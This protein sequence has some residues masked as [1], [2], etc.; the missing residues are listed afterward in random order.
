MGTI[1]R[2]HPWCVHL[3]TG[4][5]MLM[6]KQNSRTTLWN[7]EISI[8]VSCSILQKSQTTNETV[9]KL[10][11]PTVSD[12]V[13]TFCQTTSIRGIPQIANFKSKL[14][15][16]IWFMG[17]LTCACVLIWQ[18]AVVSSWFLSYPV[19]TVLVQS[20]EWDITTFPDITICN[21]CPLVH[22]NEVNLSYTDY[23]TILE[24]T[25]QFQAIWEN[26]SVI[27]YGG[28]W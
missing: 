3:F 15:S 17:V 10:T 26:L 4:F 13:K 9:S 12:E 6:H 20:E 2:S 7:F 27:Y 28:W 16:V 8:L 1:I 18:V 11:S 21:L 23:S 5:L 25:I 24:K 19:N 22:H 14:Q